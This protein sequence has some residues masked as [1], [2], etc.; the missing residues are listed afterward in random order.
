MMTEYERIAKKNGWPMKLQD[1]VKCDFLVTE[2]LRKIQLIELDLLIEFDKVC[3]ENNLKYYTIFGTLLGAVRHQGFIPWDD[4]LDVAMPRRDY[5]A[6]RKIRNEMFQQPY[7][8]QFPGEDEG[9]WFSYAKLRNSNTSCISKP[10]RYENFNQGLCIDIFPI[11]NCMISDVEENW[12]S[13]NELILEESAN[14]RRSLKNPSKNDIERMNKYLVREPKLVFE[15]INNFVQKHNLENTYFVGFPCLTV[16]SAKK[17]IFPNKLFS[18]EAKLIFEGYEFRAPKYYK[19]VLSTIYGDYMKYPPK[20]ER[21]T[22]HS[23]SI[24]DPDIPYKDML[25]MVEHN[26]L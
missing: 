20:E 26:E 14:M 5:E 8:L 22:W 16:Y 11:D 24:F 17:L 19:D 21:G 3:R 6:L 18:D 1:E 25:K 9:Y 15:E 23:T 7:F 2:K 4:D 13:I 12:T 10:F